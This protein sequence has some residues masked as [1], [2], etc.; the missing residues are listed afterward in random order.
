MPPFTVTLSGPL[1]DR[2]RA[3]AALRGH[4]VEAAPDSHGLPEDGL[5]WIDVHCDHPDQIVPLLAPTWSLRITRP[6]AAPLQAGL[7]DPVGDLRRELAEVRSQL[8]VLSS[9]AGA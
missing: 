1:A 2:P 9:R 5:G 6:V 4:H 7:S 3:I 8:A